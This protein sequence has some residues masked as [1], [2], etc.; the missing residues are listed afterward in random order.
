MM[1]Q[2]TENKVEDNLVKNQGENMKQIAGAII[3]AGFVIA[4]AILLKG[5]N[6]GTVGTEKPISK[7]IG[8]NTRSF[9]A[10]M[11]SGK[12]KVKVQASIDE[13]IKA[14]VNGTPT[15]FI[16]KDG[17]VVDMIPGAQPYEIVKVNLER[18][19][20]NDVKP[21]E[22]QIQPISA[23]D[24]ILGN[25]NAKIIVVEYSDLDCP[26]CKTFHNTM[27]QVIKNNPDVAWVYRHYPIPQLHPNAFRKAEE[28]ECAWEQK[29]ND[30]FWKYA[31][32]VFEL[33]K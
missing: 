1:E 15:S 22:K 14:G 16:V 33:A 25:T 11:E 17:I 21:I 8:L 7:I 30:G 9:D 27:H 20:K 3:I 28:T 12:W 24:H 4:G 32:K 29:G 19:S 31:D 18:I 5:N 6:N 23:D 10:C 13:G 26:F 2:N